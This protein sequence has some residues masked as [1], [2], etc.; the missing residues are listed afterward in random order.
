[1]LTQFRWTL[2][3]LAFLGLV[4]IAGCGSTEERDLFIAKGKLL[5]NG[6]PFVLDESKIQLP[7]GATA[8]PPGG[9]EGLRILFILA[10][11]KE[12]FQ[13][14]FNPESSTFEVTG[15]KGKGIKPGRYKIAVTAN[16]APTSRDA[17]SGDYFGGIFT[18]EKTQISR[19]VK[20]G[21]EIIIDVSKPKG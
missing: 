13:A 16:Y 20:E 19:E 17:D 6:K 8:P 2:V 9:G 11:T 7:K 1:M 3:L 4:S 14:K 12:Q 18:R 21:E 10:E 15:S 5:D